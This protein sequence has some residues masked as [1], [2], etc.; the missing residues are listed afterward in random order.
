VLV[1]AT[2][3]EAVNRSSQQ[4]WR[5]HDSALDESRAD[6]A[7]DGRWPS[8]IRPPRKDPSN[9]WCRAG[10]MGDTRHSSARRAYSSA[11]NLTAR[12]RRQPRRRTAIPIDCVPSVHALVSNTHTRQLHVSCRLPGGTGPA[13]RTSAVALPSTRSFEG[14]WIDRR[15]GMD[16]ERDASTRTTRVG[17]LTGGK[18]CRTLRELRERGLSGPFTTHDRAEVSRGRSFAVPRSSLLIGYDRLVARVPA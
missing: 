1:L 10:L 8:G 11:N 2:G 7:R 4:L 6:R 18:G 13:S 14:V 5:R 3:L 12:P 9:R 17:R 15:D 16:L